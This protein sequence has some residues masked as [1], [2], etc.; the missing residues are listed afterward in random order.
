[1]NET[2]KRVWDGLTHSNRMKLLSASE[3]D[4]RE[5]AAKQTEIDVEIS[6]L[7]EK[8]KT[9]SLSLDSPPKK[10][11][12]QYFEGEEFEMEMAPFRCHVNG[13][14]KTFPL[15]KCL[16]RHVQMCHGANSV[17]ASP[18]FQHVQSRPVVHTIPLVQP[19]M[20]FKR[21]TLNAE[22]VKPSKT[23]CLQQS[24]S[25]VATNVQN[26]S[27][28]PSDA[29]YRA[30]LAHLEKFGV[31]RPYSRNPTLL[32]DCPDMRP[33]VLNIVTHQASHILNRGANYFWCS[34]KA[35]K[36]V[37]EKVSDLSPQLLAEYKKKCNFFVFEEDPKKQ[38]N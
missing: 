31:D 21:P 16:L 13:C 30:N 26:S 12:C 15:R 3:K 18:Q 35:I 2:F 5:V 19:S 11:T 33:A 34:R 9:L 4:R 28:F 36:K 23:V 38:N 22:V 32:C 25:S 24:L 6:T 37:G 1:M 10:N 17:S 7:K 27:G 20:A 29:H 14:S 8:I